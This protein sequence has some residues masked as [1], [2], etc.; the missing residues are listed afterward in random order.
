MAAGCASGPHSWSQSSVCERELSESARLEG[1]TWLQ[2]LLQG[3]DPSSGRAT[4]PAVD[5]SGTQ[6]RWES[7]ALSCVDPTT[8]KTMLPDRPLTA[9]DVVA[10]AI[11]EN[12]WLVWV[13]TNRYASG[14]GLG[15]VAIAEVYGTRIS[16]RAIGPL[17]ASLV[18]PKL[19]LASIGKQEFVVAEGERCAS[20][21]PSTCARAARVV[22]LVGKDRFH[23]VPVTDASGACISPAWLDL[24][25]EEKE[26]LESG[27]VRH[28]RLDSSLVFGAKAI[29]VGEQVVINDLDPKDGAPPRQFRRA[30]NDRKLTFDGE[31]FVTDQPPLWNRMLS[32]RE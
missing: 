18:R 28:F 21:D 25:R 7:P 14:D 8:A 6:I 30:E 23:P 31:R 9:D 12:T 22:P 29:T 15:P 20:E 4:S 13:V 27:W 24:H 17:R 26:K 3:F 1:A 2:V 5:C 16:V 10:E 11:G 32:A 19:R